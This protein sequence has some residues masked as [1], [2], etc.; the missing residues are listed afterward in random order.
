ML[1]FVQITLNYIFIILYLYFLNYLLLINNININFSDIYLR[2]VPSESNLTSIYFLWTNFFYLYFLVITFT[3]LTTGLM[4]YFWNNKVIKSLFLLILV[5][6]GT[7]IT[8][9]ILLLNSVN[10]PLLLNPYL[11]NSLLSNNVNKYHP[12]LFYITFIGSILVYAFGFKSSRF[13]FISNFTHTILF[14]IFI[15]TALGS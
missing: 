3:I 15:T 9:N 11:Y 8:I 5:V 12:L 10:K 4:L 13:S 7:Y 14:S 1:S 2:I 6:I